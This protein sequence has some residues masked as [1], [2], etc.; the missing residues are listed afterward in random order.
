M[1]GNGQV[2]PGWGCAVEGKPSVMLLAALRTL[3]RNGDRPQDLP[4]CD[5][6][7]CDW[8]RRVAE[9]LRAGTCRV[10]VLF[11]DDPGLACCVANKVPGVRAAAVWTVGQAHRAL[12]GLG[13]NLLVVETADRTFY[14]CKEL[15]RLCRDR[16]PGGCP[17]GVA[18]V[19]EGLDGHAH[20]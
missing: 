20:R 17:P 13:A 12:D 3:R 8:F 11:C 9:C 7:A 4:E 5:G 18:C 19:L 14:E 6:P 1:S 15:L 2:C 10:A 16:A